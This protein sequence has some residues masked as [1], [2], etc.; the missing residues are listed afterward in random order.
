MGLG[1]PW[2]GEGEVGESVGDGDS[3]GD[4]VGD[5]EGV[6][7]GVGCAG[8]VYSPSEPPYDP[9]TNGSAGSP[10]NAPRVNSAQ[11]AV[12]NEPPVMFA[13]PPVPA[14]DTGSPFLF[15]FIIITAVESCGVYPT[16]Q[17]DLLSSVVPVLPAAGRPIHD[18]RVPDPL[19]TTDCRAAF[20]ESIE[21]SENSRSPRS[22][23]LYADSPP[24]R[25]TLWRI[26]GGVFMPLD[27]KV[28]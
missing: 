21:S 11:I 19:F 16:N 24:L 12:G 13:R 14:S 25:L 20:T 7:L 23:I 18:A 10:S 22:E 4:S 15:S 27:A 9:V 6:W 26:V 5:G 2:V 17:A 3:E 1:V 8:G 28:A